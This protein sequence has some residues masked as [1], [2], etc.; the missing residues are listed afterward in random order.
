[1]LLVTYCENAKY[2]QF[3]WSKQRAYLECERKKARW[4]TQAGYTKHLNLYMKTL[5]VV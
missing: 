2:L 3:D 5:R 1:M 4:G